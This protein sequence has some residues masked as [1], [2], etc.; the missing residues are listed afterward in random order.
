MYFVLRNNTGSGY[1]LLAQF[2]DE[3][4]VPKRMKAIPRPHS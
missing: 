2:A 3:E 1:Y 4:T